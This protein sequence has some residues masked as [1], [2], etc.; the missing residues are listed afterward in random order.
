MKLTV[1]GSGTCVPSAQRCS[2]G[3]YLE[4]ND[5]TLLVDCGSGVL[6][7]LDRAGKDFSALDAVFIT[8][9]HPDHIADLLPLIHALV[10]APGLTIK[11]PVPVFGPPEI[12]TFIDA[13]VFS[14]MKRIETLPVMFNE[15]GDKIDINDLFV[16]SSKT[17]HSE[18]SFAYRFEQGERSVVLT[19]DSDY[20]RSLVEFSMKATLLIADCSFPDEEKVAGHMTPRE[21]GRLAKEAGVRTLILSHIYPS[22]YPETERVKECRK[23][24]DGTVILAEDLMEFDV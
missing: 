13:C 24:Y 18:N 8:H 14:L 22:H 23:V 6:R 9:A 12:G 20:E 19:G 10:A 11:K 17:L 1:L 7:Q 16:F 2:P 4:T 15:A 3:Y 21:C 5:T